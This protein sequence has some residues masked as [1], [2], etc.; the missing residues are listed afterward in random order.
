L[1]RPVNAE[2][3]GHRDLNALHELVVP[4]RL[5][6]GVREAK[7]EEILHRFL[8]EE[9]VDPIDA[10]FVELTVERVV[11]RFRRG[12]I[13]PEWLFDHNARTLRAPRPPQSVGHLGERIGW[14]R[15]IVQRML[16]R[17]EQGAK[18]GERRS[19]SSRLRDTPMRASSRSTAPASYSGRCDSSSR[20][21]FRRSSIVQPECA[22][23]MTGIS[24]RPCRV[25]ASSAA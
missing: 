10:R 5:E 11:E 14:N 25:S 15:E 16:R 7:H 2:V 13:A 21:R 3:L 12:E 4:H 18:L 6:K 19:C 22:M 17:G 24:R 23:Q 9:V 8:A 1:P 20:M